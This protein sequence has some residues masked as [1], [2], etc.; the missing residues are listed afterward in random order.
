MMVAL[1]DP[2]RSER[3]VFRIVRCRTLL[4]DIGECSGE[5]GQRPGH[6]VRTLGS[7]GLIVVPAGRDVASPVT[8]ANPMPTLSYHRS[9]AHSP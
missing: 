4:P 3:A 1:S 8:E 2:A 5:K 9:Y 6:W 7:L